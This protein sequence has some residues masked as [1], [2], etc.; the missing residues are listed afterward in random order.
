M[1]KSFSFAPTK[2]KE[3]PVLQSRTSQ[4]IYGQQS[5]APKQQPASSA[6]KSII[7]GAV[8]AFPGA[9]TRSSGA[10]SKLGQG[11]AQKVIDYANSGAPKATKYSSS[12]QVA[13]A[14]GPGAN[15]QGPYVQKPQPQAPVQ[16]PELPPGYNPGGNNQ[17]QQGQ[18]QP[19]TSYVDDY[20]NER[21]RIAEERAGL[22]DQAY[23]ENQEV[24]RQ[25]M[26]L[27][28][29]DLMASRGDA[30]KALAGFK[31]STQATIG[32]LLASGARQKESGEREMGSAQRRA[33]ADKRR[34]DQ[35]RQSKFASLG[36]LDSYGA[37]GYTGQQTE[38]DN[39]YSLAN[40]NMEAQFAERMADVDQQVE[41][42]VRNAYKAI[43][44]EEIK[45]NAL[46]RNIDSSMAKGSIEHSNAMN[47]AYR[48][49]QNATLGMQDYI[50]GI[51]NEAATIKMQLQQQAQQLANSDPFANMSDEFK[52]TGQLTE[53]DRFFLMK[54][55]EVAKAYKDVYSASAGKSPSASSLQVSGKAAAGLRAIDHI[56]QEIQNNPSI[57]A[58]YQM[59]G[60][61]GARTY[62]AAVSS[63]TDAIGGLRTGASVSPEQQK[64]YENMLPRVGD[65]PSTIAY[66]LGEVRKE[67]SGYQQAAPGIQEPGSSLSEDQIQQII[68]SL[69]Q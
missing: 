64:F 23:R 50:A 44:D 67:L 52:Q 63:L 46:V 10:A 14:Q 66:K 1:F 65:D 2:K 7:G 26:E 58:Q 54:N 68:G 19:D 48:E 53:Q 5:N 29:G 18:Q 16:G 12:A 62:A 15:K 39:E 3:Q 56:E 22:N 11:A 35:M 42:S 8:G 21:K 6:F 4:P 33:A 36:T 17:Q 32:D 40:R 20:F 9:T 24:Q 37:Q 60:S 59:P 34:T 30:E 55:P 69:G 31:E 43:Q 49:Y 47:T 25:L 13:G 51:E 38:A 41:S 45:F 61:P 27:Q 57:I 28:R